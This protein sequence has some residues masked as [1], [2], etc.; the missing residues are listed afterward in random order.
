MVRT[1]QPL[2]PSA[3]P[4]TVLAEFTQGYLTLRKSYAEAL[5]RATTDAELRRWQNRTTRIRRYW[6]LLNQENLAE[7]LDGVAAIHAAQ[8]AANADIAAKI[9]AAQ[10]VSPR[11]L[12]WSAAR[13]TRSV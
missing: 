1:A 12:H 3:V 9:A 4:A 10:S 8:Q 11:Q 6:D 13:C 5:T 7:V 2:H